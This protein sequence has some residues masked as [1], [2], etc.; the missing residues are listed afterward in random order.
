MSEL[1]MMVID[2]SSNA[3][4]VLADVDR[5]VRTIVEDWLGWGH[6]ERLSLARRP[7]SV[8]QDFGGRFC[9]RSWM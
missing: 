9:E 4:C 5:A 6:D 8:P 1:M 7:M 2:E 3:R